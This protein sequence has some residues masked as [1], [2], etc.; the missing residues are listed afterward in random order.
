MASA[1]QHRVRPV[2]DMAVP[3]PVRMVRLGG[4][5][6]APSSMV[7][8]TA[9]EAPV[10]I[11]YMLGGVVGSAAVGAGIGYLASGRKQGAITGALAG[12]GVWAGTGAFSEFT[13]GHAMMGAGLG[14]LSVGA[15]VY[16]WLR[17][18]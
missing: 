13:L 14:V 16:S 11:G 6:G 1:Y 18:P 15:L 4:T 7:A 12:T 2:A 10:A 17:K 9:V 3:Q 5:V 8:S